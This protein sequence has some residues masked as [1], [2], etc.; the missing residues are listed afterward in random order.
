[1][2]DRPPDPRAQ[3]LADYLRERASAF[4]LSADSTNEHHIA[5]AGMALL[6]AAALAGRLPR[7]D[8]R[9]HALSAAG[10]FEAM[11]GGGCRFVETPA[12]RAIVQ[13]PLSGTPM[14][15]DQILDLLAANAQTR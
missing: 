6:D 8:H 2:S 5:Q 3:A 13:R 4:S 7:S 1:M 12:L 11:P 10:R 15:G 9:L 14:S